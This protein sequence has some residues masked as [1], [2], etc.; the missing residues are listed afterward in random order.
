[1]ASASPPSFVTVATPSKVT[2]ISGVG[3]HYYPPVESGNRKLRPLNAEIPTGSM[4]SVV[5]E[6]TAFLTELSVRLGRADAN[7]KAAFFTHIGRRYPVGFRMDQKPV[8]GALRLTRSVEIMSLYA[9]ALQL[10]ISSDVLR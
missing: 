2:C 1:M 9:P 4:P 5:R 10:P 7:V 6:S 3:C 8:A